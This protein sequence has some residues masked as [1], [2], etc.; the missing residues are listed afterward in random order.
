M[1]DFY[2]RLFTNPNQKET[3]MNILVLVETVLCIQVSSAMCE[4]EFSTMARIRSDWHTRLAPKML[5]FLMAVSIQG[6]KFMDYNAT[7]DF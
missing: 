6:P 4:Q 1:Y 5:N 2:H 3:Q 7:R